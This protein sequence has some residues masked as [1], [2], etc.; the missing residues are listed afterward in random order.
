MAAWHTCQSSYWLK[1]TLALFPAVSS[2][3]KGLTIHKQGSQ[4]A[5]HYCQLP[6]CLW[7][8][9]KA[10]EPLKEV[11]FHVDPKETIPKYTHES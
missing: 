8:P 2:D 4:L 9:E 7:T 1:A 10:M 3:A 6:K 5:F 11:G